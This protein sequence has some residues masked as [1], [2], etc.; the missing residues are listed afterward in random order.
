MAQGV[1]ELDIALFREIYTPHFDSMTDAAIEHWWGVACEFVDNTPASPIP[2]DPPNV[3]SRKAILYALLCHLCE[4]ALRGPGGVGRTTN[5]TQGSVSVGMVSSLDQLKNA[6]W[7]TQTQCG[8]SAY[9]MLKTYGV[10]G[11][12]FNGGPKY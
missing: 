10:G 6:A 3:N 2:Y 5:A 8:A 1:V 12:W 9:E 7:W 4:L 11:W